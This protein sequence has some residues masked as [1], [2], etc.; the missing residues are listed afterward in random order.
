MNDAL[1]RRTML[2]AGLGAAALAGAASAQAAPT[3]DGRGF[4]LRP[5]A[6]DLQTQALERALQ[7]SASSGHALALE[8]GVYRIAGA[9][10]P[11]GTILTGT[12]RVVLPQGGDGPILQAEGIASA[13]L[14][15]FS[16]HGE[17]GRDAP[18]G[19]LAGV[20]RAHISG[21]TAANAFASAFNLEG[22]G[23]R[24]E[25]CRITQASVAIFA[26]DSTGLMI[27]G[28]EIDDCA[29]N[30]IQVWR[31]QKGFDG[32]QVL[33]NRITRIRSDRGGSGEYGNGV[34][35]FRAG[36]VLVSDNVIRACAFSAV[37]NNAGDAVQI[38][39]NNC[40]DLG[41]VGLFT[42]FGFEGCVIAGNIVDGAANGIVS[43]NF[44]DGGR[45]SVISG[46]IVRKL[47]RRPD[48]LSGEIL[49]GIGIVAEADAAVTGNVVEDA[50]H[51]GI[52]IGYGPYLRDVS[53]TGNVL[54]DCLI[55][56]IVS[57]VDGTG[58]AQI[59]NNLISGARDG[60]IVGFRWQERATGDLAADQARGHPRIALAGNI[61]H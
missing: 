28:N 37:R 29:N 58:R 3:V 53:A 18:L 8:P 34:N 31:S 47:F 52:A 11:E 5:D 2:S 14:S 57:V 21:V 15:G 46:N 33:A 19:A 60:A 17:I 26:R 12:P 30:G 32:T 16:L 35:V 38:I 50:P 42:E 40:A 44:N 7:A 23:G 6:P 13:A 20:A 56:F 25:Q 4:G 45:M 55:G 61:A 10:L 36:G 59:A 27:T 41:E 24:I 22:C 54:R 48:P 49:Y 51:A 9:R 43:T 1:S 39:A